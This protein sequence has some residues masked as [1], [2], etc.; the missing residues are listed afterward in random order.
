MQYSDSHDYSFIPQHKFEQTR[1]NTLPP[2]PPNWSPKLKM[3]HQSFLTSIGQFLMPVSSGRTT[4]SLSQCKEHLFLSIT[5]RV[6]EK[7]KTPSRPSPCFRHVSDYHSCSCNPER[8]PLNSFCSVFKQKYIG[9]HN[10]KATSSENEALVTIQDRQ[11]RIWVGNTNLHIFGSAP[12]ESDP[13]IF[14]WEQLII[15][16][17]IQSKLETSFEGIMAGEPHRRD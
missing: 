4:I 15:T 6:K 3:S 10:S 5:C 9:P 17:Q 13:E 1:D 2:H 8:S 11:C 16:R 7:A 12:F 14:F